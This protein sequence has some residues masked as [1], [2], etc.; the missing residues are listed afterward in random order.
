MQ[1]CLG[2]NDAKDDNLAAARAGDFVAGFEGLLRDIVSRSGPRL[3]TLLI[4][5]PTPIYEYDAWTSGDDGLA[6]ERNS[7]T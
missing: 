3:Q 6:A 4:C 2:T 1:V 5:S 7:T